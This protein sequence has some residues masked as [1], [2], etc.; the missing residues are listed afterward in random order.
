MTEVGS[1]SELVI[2][3][4]SY[5]IPALS[6]CSRAEL[7]G[8]DLILRDRCSISPV[9]G[10]MTHLRTFIISRRKNLSDFI[11]LND[12]FDCPKLEELVLDPRLNGEKFDI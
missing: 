1:T 5:T 6:S 10:L 11:S 2:R 8:G 9:L 7:A 12:R 4:V 3:V